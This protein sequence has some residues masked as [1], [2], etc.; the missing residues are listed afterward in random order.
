MRRSPPVLLIWLVLSLT[1]TAGCDSYSSVSPEEHIQRAKDFEG[2]K[3]LK[4][5]TLELKNAVAKAPDNPEAR[6]LLGQ[7]YAQSGQ[8]EAAEKELRR[9]REL[10]VRAETIL[11]LLGTALIQQGEF[12][13]VLD[14]IQPQPD[15]S[16]LNQSRIA[17]LRGD[18]LIGLGK[19]DTGCALYRDAHALDAGNIIAYHGLAACDW[20]KGKREEAMRWLEQALARAPQDA[21]TLRLLGQ[22]SLESGKLDQASDY[23]KRAIASVPTAIAPHTQLGILYLMQDRHDQARAEARQIRAIVPKHPDADYLEAFAFYLEK[24]YP[25]AL[26]RIQQALKTGSDVPAYLLL[27]GTILLEQGSLEQAQQTL[28]RILLQQPGHVAARKLQALAALRIGQPVESKKLLQPIL[29]ASLQ[30]T[31]AQVLAGKAELSRAQWQEAERYQ[32]AALAREPDNAAALVDLGQALAGQN[33]LEEALA[34]FEQARKLDNAP[35]ETELLL[36]RTHLRAGQPAE[37]LRIAQAR[38]QLDPKAEDAYLLAAR[39]QLMLRQGGT[40]RQTLRQA[41]THLPDAIAPRAMLAALLIQDKQP[42]EAESLWRDLLERQPRNLT[43]LLTLAQIAASDARPKEANALLDRAAREAPDSPQVALALASRALNEGKPGNAIN[44]LRSALQAHPE[45]PDLLGALGE[46]Q[47]AQQDP[48]NARSNFERAIKHDTRNNPRWRLG[49]ALAE[50]GLGNLTS[51][52]R[53]LESAIRAHPG[54][55]PAYE[56]LALLAMRE[57]K[58]DE[59]LQI[60][61][62]SQ[63]SLPGAADPFLLEGDVLLALRKWDEAAAPLAKA[64]SLAPSQSTLLKLFRARSRNGA[65]KSSDSL[66]DDWLAR[67]PQDTGVRLARAELRLARLDLPGAEADYRAVLAS[68][69]RQIDALNNL[70]FILQDKNAKESLDLARRAHAIAPENPNVLDTYGW[71]LAN[72]PATRQQG[73]A[74]LEQAVERA[75]QIPAYRLHLARALILANQPEAARRHLVPL[76]QLKSG[77]IR[78]EAASLLASL[79]KKSP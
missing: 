26:S 39:A 72:Q 53:Q 36:I 74:L 8:G 31:G 51:A 78:T 34:I 50:F 55:Y 70:A 29:L 71:L 41:L 17:S 66:L 32:R 69:P 3:E 22:R 68:Q 10:G 19:I 45:R 40:A 23:F 38:I 57:N 15:F 49:L 48:S 52:R 37:A 12:Q 79:D 62:R 5:A 21:V 35:S 20:V 1:T 76:S 16:R 56:Q 11:P 6:L 54:Y 64:F 2:K 59:A 61:R 63:V 73:M 75:P 9:A 46:A 65:I 4:A 60:A 25:D 13:K 24:Q 58:P 42:R 28:A 33:K 44:A 43:A 30:D 18:A 7:L 14:S 47:L 77:A 67:R 27:H